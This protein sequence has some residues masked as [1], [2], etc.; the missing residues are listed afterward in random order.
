[1]KT[2]SKFL[3]A[4]LMSAFA[5]V[6]CAQTPTKTVKTAKLSAEDVTKIKSALERNKSIWYEDSVVVE[7]LLTKNN[8][9]ISGTIT[10][11]EEILSASEAGDT[12]IAYISYSYGSYW[13]TYSISRKDKFVGST[14]I[15]LN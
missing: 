10:E 13:L 14:E 5:S 3:V 9:P 8:V 2:I 7:T 6:V 4:V 15:R 12:W 11:D 1:M